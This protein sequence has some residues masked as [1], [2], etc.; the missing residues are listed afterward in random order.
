[1][2]YGWCDEDP[3]YMSSGVGKLTFNMTNLRADIAFYYF[4]NGTYSP[5]MVYTSDQVVQFK[6]INEPLRPRV[7]ATGDPDVLTLM[8]SSANSAAPVMRWGVS[9]DNLDHTAS[10]DTSR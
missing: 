7:V 5:I 8:W 10:A 6:N 9:K 1:M 4:T 2:K 3:D